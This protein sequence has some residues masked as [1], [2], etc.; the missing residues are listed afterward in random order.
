LPVL[1][2]PPSPP[3]A[4]PSPPVAVLLPWFVVDWFD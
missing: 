4:V 1:A 2:L 3:V